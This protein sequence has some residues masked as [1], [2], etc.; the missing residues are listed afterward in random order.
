MGKT[1]S[2]NITSFNP[3]SAILDKKYLQSFSSFSTIF[4]H[5]TRLLSTK[6]ECTS[7]LRVAKRLIKDLWKSGNFKKISE[8]LRTHGKYPAGHPKCK[9]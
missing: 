1:K 4:L 5:L 7:Y 6:G 8:M 2:H 3:V 9:F